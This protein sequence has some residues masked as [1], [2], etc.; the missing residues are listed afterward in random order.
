MKIGVL[1]R[2]PRSAYECYS[3]VR[4]GLTS[5]EV[6]KYLAIVRGLKSA[7]GSFANASYIAIHACTCKM[8]PILH[9]TL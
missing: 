3:K 9:H 5:A 6:A 8:Q 1:A 4:F 2:R 7:N